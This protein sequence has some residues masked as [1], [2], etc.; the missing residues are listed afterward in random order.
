MPER[1]ECTT[2]DK[3]ALYKYFSFPFLSVMSLTRCVVSV[4]HV[5]WSV[6]HVIDWLCDLCLSCVWSV[7]H[8]TDWLC[9]LCWLSVL[10]TFTGQALDLWFISVDGR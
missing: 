8:V 1:F 5:V 9:G 2:L 6:S 10:C 3:K 4:C 7:C